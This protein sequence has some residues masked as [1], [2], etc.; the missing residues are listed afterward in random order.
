MINSLLLFF[1]ITIII[2]IVAIVI[3][4]LLR[5]LTG[6]WVFYVDLRCPWSGFDVTSL[7][8][9]EY[10]ASVSNHWTIGQSLE[11]SLFLQTN[12]NSEE[13]YCERGKGGKGEK[14]SL[15]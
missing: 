2:V 7:F 10:K 11:K 12:N 3:I 14:K 13:N 4:N 9:R 5:H 1:I 8:Q 15:V 6:L